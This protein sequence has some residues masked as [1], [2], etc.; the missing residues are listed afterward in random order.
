MSKLRDWVITTPLTSISAATLAIAVAGGCTAGT[1][2]NSVDAGHHDSGPDIPTTPDVAS[3]APEDAPDDIDID[4]PD[5]AGWYYPPDCPNADPT[6]DDDDDGWTVEEGDCNDCTDYMNPGAFD[7]PNTNADENCDGIID[8]DTYECD[9]GIA[10]DSNDAMDAARAIGLCR[11]AVRDA[12]KP[13]RTWGVLSAKYVFPDGTTASKQPKTTGSDCISG[14]GKF[15][16]PPHPKSHGILT[17]F[18]KNVDPQGGKAMLA[19]SSGI[20]RS[21]AVESSPGGA[22]MC[23]ASN[24][25]PGFPQQSASACPGQPVPT[26]KTAHD[27]IALELEIRVPSNAKGFSFDFNFFTYEFPEF[28]CKQ[29]NDF[30]VALMWPAISDKAV[31]N[32]IA[33]DKDGNPVSVNNGFLEVCKQEGIY[34]GKHFTCALGNE[35]L[36]G[37]GF[38][39][40]GATGWLRT[41]SPV[42][43]GEIIKLRF[44]IWDAKDEG[45][46][47][48]VLIDNFTWHLKE[49]PAETERPPIK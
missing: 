21:G 10:E 16:S 48:T 12:P 32:N 39:G 43:P 49:L 38:D 5:S 14:G 27:G 20:A 8:N 35:Q 22:P 29:Y 25:P 45:F 34:G 44:A 46:D 9:D 30:F 19:L 42:E 31:N 33:F 24:T 3:E 15:G 2:D 23:T 28:V 1:P 11:V 40:A 37:T 6:G 36:K 47:S 13:T 26:D 18:G 4:G 7:Y 17:K 41:S